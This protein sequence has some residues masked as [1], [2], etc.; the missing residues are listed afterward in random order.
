MR[1]AKKADIRDYLNRCPD[2][3][4]GDLDKEDWYWSDFSNQKNFNP[5]LFNN[6]LKFWS[7]VLIETSKRG[8]LSEDILC[9]NRENLGEVFSVHRGVSPLGLNCVI[10]KLQY[11]NYLI[12]V[13][14]FRAYSCFL[15]FLARIVS[16]LRINSY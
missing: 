10:V 16:L 13:N 11:L 7:N 8:W 15:S 4:D 6:A 12:I 5:I 1:P 3:R 9:L 14:E 2:L